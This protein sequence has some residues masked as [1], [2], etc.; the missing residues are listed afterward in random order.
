MSQNSNK[1]S[2]FY[3]TLSRPRFL[4]GV[5]GNIKRILMSMLNRNLQ[6]SLASSNSKTPPNSNT[7]SQLQ[8]ERKKTLSSFFLLLLLLLLLLLSLR[9]NSFSVGVARGLSANK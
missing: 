1:I 5:I 8:K 2:N 3:T 9:N 7:T 4:V 6:R